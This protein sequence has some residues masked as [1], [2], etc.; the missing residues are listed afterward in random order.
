MKVFDLCWEP[1][2]DV[3]RWTRSWTKALASAKALEATC[4]EADD[5]AAIKKFYDQAIK[6]TA[7]IG[8]LEK[9]AV[10]DGNALKKAADEQSQLRRKGAGLTNFKNAGGRNDGV[11]AAG[12]QIETTTESLDLNREQAGQT[13]KPRPPGTLPAPGGA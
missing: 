8:V 12:D 6:A 11:D 9:K 10:R 5:A 3:L 4:S 7:A 1:V 2:R 13:E